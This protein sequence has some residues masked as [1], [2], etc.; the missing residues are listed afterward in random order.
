VLSAQWNSVVARKVIKRL[1]KSIEGL[2]VAAKIQA[3][4]GEGPAWNTQLGVL[5]SVDIRGER[6]YTYN[7]TL[8]TVESFSTKSAPGAV[9]PTTGNTL[10]IALVDGIYLADLDGSNLVNKFM[11]E[12]EILGNR[13]N[14]AKCDPNGVLFA[15]TMGDKKSPSGSLYRINSKSFEKVCKDVI[16]SNG[17]GWNTDG[18]KMYFIDSGRRSVQ[19]S[20]YDLATSSIIGFKNFIEFPVSFGIPDGL[21]ADQEGGIWVAFFGGQ[22]VRR[23][24]E[25]GI[26]THEIHLPAPLVTSCCFA[27][28]DSTI[29]YI[30]TAS[31]DLGDGRT[32]GSE[33]GNLFCIDVGIP[34]S[35]TVP[36][37]L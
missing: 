18:S 36:F 17:L 15:G 22:Q 23:F 34:G 37:A 29:L 27:G 10:A 7:P 3:I 35:G 12:A 5:H 14:D 28:E 2:E 30:T 13:M 24:S 1:I 21:C 11:I 6:V 32:I 25:S 16:V 4:V 9:L 19:V 26:Q 8:G 33:E 20:D 31:I